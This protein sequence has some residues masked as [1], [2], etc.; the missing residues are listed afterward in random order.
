[1]KRVTI[2]GCV[3]VAIVLVFAAGVGSAWLLQP[4]PRVLKQADI[5]AAVLHTLQTKSLPSR[6]ARAAEAVRQSVVAI[7]SFP[8]AKPV[9]A[10][11]SPPAKPGTR[12]KRP[13][14]SPTTRPSDQ[15][16]VK[17]P[18]SEPEIRHIGSGVVVTESGIIITNHHVVADAARLE[19]SFHDGH[20][21]EAVVLQALPEKDLAIL[22]AKSMPDDLPPATLGSSRELAPGSE[23]VAVGFPFG[24]GPSVSAGVVSGLDRE[25]ISPDNKEHLD[26]LIQFDA[27]AN[28]GN[29][30][31]PLVNMNG[32]V[33]G[34]VTA[35]LNPNKSGTF[36]GI[37]FAI[38]IES[39]G[40]SVGASPF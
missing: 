12:A 36:L 16:T 8:A 37:G 32:E 29:S 24:I 11:S 26:K 33:V 19:I 20:T 17:P 14:S 4:K 18:A 23:V 38:T 34:I 6:T 7:R 28:P 5:D 3:S 10:A 13:E 27:A 21:A 22:Q 2:Y 15:A 39:A 35:I 25:F 1:M 9:E 30:G 31:G 40:G